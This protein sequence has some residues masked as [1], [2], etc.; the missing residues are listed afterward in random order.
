MVINCL[1]TILKHRPYF[2]SMVIPAI[3]HIPDQLS[4]ISAQSQ[5]PSIQHAIRTSLS[6]MAKIQHASIRPFLESLLESLTILGARTEVRKREETKLLTN[7]FCED[8][9]E[10]ETTSQ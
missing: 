6:S 4:S 3:M 8:G 5:L 2:A 9:S 10:F 1:T 7:Y